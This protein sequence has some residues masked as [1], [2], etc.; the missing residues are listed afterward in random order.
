MKLLPMPPRDKDTSLTPEESLI[1]VD[2]ASEFVFESVK[3]LI[4]DGECPATELVLIDR[5]AC[6]Q[7]ALDGLG[8]VGQGHNGGREQSED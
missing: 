6:T 8:V 2:L 5:C 3:S 1:G 4:H 7:L